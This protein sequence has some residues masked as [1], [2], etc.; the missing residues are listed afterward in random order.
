MTCTKSGNE[1]ELKGNSGTTSVEDNPQEIQA[2]NISFSGVAHSAWHE[3]NC[4][5]VSEPK[6]LVVYW[7]DRGAKVYDVTLQDGQSVD[8]TAELTLKAKVAKAETHKVNI[9]E[10]KV[11]LDKDLEIDIAAGQDS[12]EKD[13]KVTC[14]FNGTNFDLVGADGTSKNQTVFKVDGKHTSHTTKTLISVTITC[15]QKE[16][17]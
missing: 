6:E 9:L 10:R 2:E 4:I 16:E 7:Y 5:G 12:G 1:W 15:E 11:V 14:Q 3:I 8:L 17:E 13:F